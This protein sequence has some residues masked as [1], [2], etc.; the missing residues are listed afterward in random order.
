MNKENVKKWIEALRSDNYRQIVGN[1]YDGLYDK[2]VH[3]ACAY[4]V[5]CKIAAD[6]G[7]L[8]HSVDSAGSLKAFF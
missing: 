5:A 1:L 2:D 8:K 6:E 4:G 7:Y 3:C